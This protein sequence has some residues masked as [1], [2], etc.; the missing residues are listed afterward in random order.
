MTTTAMERKSP[1]VDADEIA[2][3]ASVDRATVLRW[4]REGRIPGII[5]TPRTIRFHLAKVLKKLG[6]ED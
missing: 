2:I 3:R 1:Y 5:L 6:L 4:H